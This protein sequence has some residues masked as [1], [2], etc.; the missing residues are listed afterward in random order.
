M[1]TPVWCFLIPGRLQADPLGIIRLDDRIAS[2]TVHVSSA[3]ATVDATDPLLWQNFFSTSDISW[4]LIRG[5][6]GVRN[7]DLIV[8]GQNATPVILSPK[9]GQIDWTLYSAVEIRMSADSGSEIKI[10][11]GNF[12][13]RQP[14]GPANQYNV[15]SFPVDVDA[16]KGA[17]MLGIMP[18]D[19]VNGTAAIHSIKLI[20]KR[21]EFTQPH[22]FAF[23]GKQDEYRR[24]LYVHSP[25]TV[26]WPLTLP[27]KA[28]LHFGMGA[29]ARGSGIGFHVRVEGTRGDLFSKALDEVD[30]W[31]DGDVDLSRWSGQRVKL[32]LET[33]AARNGDVALWANPVIVSA[34]R[35]KPPPNVLIYTIDTLRADHA[36]VYGY[37]RNT[38]PFL[39]RLAATGIV[40]DDCQAQTTWTKASIASLM[41]SL[42][43]FTHGI[44]SDAD[45]IPPG[46]NTLAEQLRAAG[47]VTSSIVSS[48]Y[49]GRATGLQRGFDYLLEFPVVQR[50]RTPA[51]GGTDSAALNRVLF[52]WL[53]QHAAEPFFLYAHAT[54]PHAP[55]APPAPFVNLF[56]SAKE[57]ASFNRLYD[58]FRSDHQYGGGVVVNRERLEKAGIDPDTYNRE[59][60]DGYDAE[61]AHNDHQLQLLV[62]ELKRLGVAENTLIIILSDHGEEF[63]DHGWTAHG[64]TVYQEL[65]HAVLLMWDPSMLGPPRRVS[66]P[67]QLIDVMPTVLDLL[68]LKLPA[69]I[70]GQSLVPLTRGQ[71][72]KRR[73]IVVSSRFAVP[74]PEGLVPENT[75]DDFAI[76]EPH[77]KFI[78]R[79]RAAHANIKRL[80]LYDRL[81]DR[82]EQHD[83]ASTQ[84][85]EVERMMSLLRPWIA[86]QNKIRAV[87]G[88]P[89]TTKLDPQTLQQLRSLGYLGGTP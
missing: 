77:W 44:V 29:T 84:E 30:Q 87:I 73:G 50:Q 68:G 74:R 26:T 82:Q 36:S 88:E 58:R 48:P 31:S 37:G 75:T 12:Q 10:K 89:G 13:A 17:R 64:H 61:I 9:E 35:P 42:S 72:F 5:R 70:E 80:E 59:A 41:T 47:Y 11:I 83:V 14:L 52:G 8:Q 46:S 78:Y 21:A 15:Y 56:G 28:H 57:N 25:S 54:D 60:M 20:P 55:Y 39:K 69:I 40:F 4:Q 43:A 16:P 85:N 6:I 67:V 63:F 22:G 65:T 76:I 62:D 18:T 49:V 51:D 19:A 24:A 53:R 2:A 81:A 71:P 1:L 86:A 79:N 3:G 66:E 33:T 38:T 27:A 7:G 45:T 32:T 23:L 34:E